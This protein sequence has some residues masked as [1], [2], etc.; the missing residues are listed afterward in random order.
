MPSVLQSVGAVNDPVAE[1]SCGITVAPQDARAV[2]NRLLKMMQLAPAARALMGQ[3][4]REFVLARHT[5][6]VLA[7]RF[8]QALQARRGDV[9]A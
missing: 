8:L 5:Y 4:G 3:R 6:P 7:K 2:A 1:V 9:D